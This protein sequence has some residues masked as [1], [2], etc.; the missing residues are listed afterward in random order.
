MKPVAELS[1][2]QKFMK[3]HYAPVI[4][5]NRGVQA[6]TVLVFLGLIAAGAYGVSDI[7]LGFPVVD[8]TP[9]DH[10]TRSFLETSERCGPSPALLT[11][12]C[13]VA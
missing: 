6:G 4:T 2:M 1:L 10:Y 13:D 5:R 3:R 11:E 8:L 7:M 9:D 12:A